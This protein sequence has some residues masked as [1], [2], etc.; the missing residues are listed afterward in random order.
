VPQAKESKQPKQL[1]EFADKY[2]NIVDWLLG[3]GW[4]EIDQTEKIRSRLIGKSL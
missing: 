4:I 2:P 1:D 3:E